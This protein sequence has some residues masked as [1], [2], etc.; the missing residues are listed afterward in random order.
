MVH[1]LP[2]KQIRITDLL[3]RTESEFADGVK[4]QH[5]VIA[6][7]VILCPHRVYTT[8]ADDRLVDL[9]VKFLYFI[10]HNLPHSIPFG[11]ERSIRQDFEIVN[12]YSLRDIKPICYNVRIVISMVFQLIGTHNHRLPGAVLAFVFHLDFCK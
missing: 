6:H 3:L 8:A 12:L 4:H 7:I 1:R 5:P 9:I 11:T 2:R 10:F